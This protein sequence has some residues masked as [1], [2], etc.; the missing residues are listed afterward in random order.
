VLDAGIFT[1]GIEAHENAPL[2]V[3]TFP[4]SNFARAKARDSRAFLNA[5]SSLRLATFGRSRTTR[6]QEACEQEGKRNIIKRDAKKIRGQPKLSSFPDTREAPRS[7]IAPPSAG[8]VKS[9]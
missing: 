9:L 1:R 2:D 3:K 6:C 5:L 4:R 7:N 8:V